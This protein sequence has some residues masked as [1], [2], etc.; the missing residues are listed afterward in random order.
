M[1]IVVVAVVDSRKK[2]GNA[3]SPH[4]TLKNAT[5]QTL[6]GCPWGEIDDFEG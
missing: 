3:N 2:N 5:R 6:L 1:V 4:V